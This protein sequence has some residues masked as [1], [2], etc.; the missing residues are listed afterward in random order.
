[1]NVEQ[2]FSGIPM[3][4]HIK[5]DKILFEGKYPVLFTCVNGEEIY[6]FSC[7]LVNSKIIKWIGSKTNYKSLIAL[8]KNEKTIYDTFQ[9]VIDEKIVIEYNGEKVIYEIKDRALIPE[10]LFPTKGEYMD[11]EED[12]F[13]EEIS[14]FEQ[15]DGYTQILIAKSSLSWISLHYQAQMIN[16]PQEDLVLDVHDKR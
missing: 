13:I 7:C 1:M 3:F 5:L 9:D 15:R 12:E 4:K 8:L 6:L 16:W 2:I 11:A 14:E 10:H